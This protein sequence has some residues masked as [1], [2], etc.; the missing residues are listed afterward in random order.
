MLE[1]PQ[2]ARTAKIGF[3][4]LEMTNEKDRVPAGSAAKALKSY[5][6]PSLAKGPVLSQITAEDGA[7]PVKVG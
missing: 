7:S 5:E 3:W 2:L 1:W 4:E 6:K